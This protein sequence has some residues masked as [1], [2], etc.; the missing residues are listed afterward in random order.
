MRQVN[1]AVRSDAELLI[2]DIWRLEGQNAHFEIVGELQQRL[3]NIDAKQYQVM[4]TNVKKGLA[5]NLCISKLS[6]I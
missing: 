3:F 6:F 2:N 1:P 5:Y 4:F